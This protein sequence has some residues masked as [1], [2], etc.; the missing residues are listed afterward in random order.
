MKKM[1]I[2]ILCLA[3][4]AVAQHSQKSAFYAVEGL[5]TDGTVGIGAS[6]AGITA[7]DTVFTA[8]FVPRWVKFTSGA[9]VWYSPVYADTT[10]KW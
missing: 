8:G 4:L 3:A 6:N 9:K 2:I 5:K 7:V 10:G 1:S